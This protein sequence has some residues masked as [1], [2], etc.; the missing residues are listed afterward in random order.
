MAVHFILKIKECEI[1]FFRASACCSAA[2]IAE[3]CTHKL[4]FLT[5]WI[6]GAFLIYFFF[7]RVYVCVC[8]VASGLLVFSSSESG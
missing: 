5:F 4:I 8:D 7:F 2:L 1:I 6:K 3:L